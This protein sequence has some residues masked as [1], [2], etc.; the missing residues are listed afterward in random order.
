MEKGERGS[1]MTQLR[2]AK[3]RGQTCYVVTQGV[4]EMSMERKQENEF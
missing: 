1:W 4:R 3:K 2:W